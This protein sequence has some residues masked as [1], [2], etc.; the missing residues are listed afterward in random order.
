MYVTG[1]SWDFQTRLHSL[2]TGLSDLSGAGTG[3]FYYEATGYT[4]INSGLLYSWNEEFAAKWYEITKTGLP[5][6]QLISGRFT[7]ILYL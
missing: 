6:S 7:P 2:P 4:G 3:N 1:H 5:T